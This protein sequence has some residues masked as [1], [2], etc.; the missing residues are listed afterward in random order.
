MLFFIFVLRVLFVWEK[1]KRKKNIYEE[2]RPIS[3][4]G[5]GWWGSGFPLRLTPPKSDEF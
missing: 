1:R 4:K 2:R 5:G 3:K